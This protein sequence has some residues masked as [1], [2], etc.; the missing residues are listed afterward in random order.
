MTMAYTTCST[1]GSVTGHASPVTSKPSDKRDPRRAFTLI[2][3]LVVVA[4]IALLVSILLP[5]LAGAR[6]KAQEVQCATNLRTCGQSTAYYLEAN[7]DT[8]FHTNW[9]SL[10]HK[11]VTRYSKKKVADW[12]DPNMAASCEF[13]LCPGDSFYHQSSEVS[14]LIN[15]TPNRVV[16][17]LSYGVNDS[18]LCPVKD[19][20]LGQVLS[21]NLPNPFAGYS[22]EAF[23]AIKSAKIKGYDGKDQWIQTGMRKSGSVPRPADV[24]LLMDAGDDDMEIGR[25]DFRQEKEYHNKRELQVHHKTGDNFLYADY[26]VNYR[27]YARSAYQRNAPPFPWSWLP[28]KTGRA[29]TRTTNPIDAYLYPDDYPY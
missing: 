21:A 1:G 11:Y 17:A 29:V 23:L 2:E 7:R 3:V 5:S 8:Y 26:H 25:W 4:I 20:M 18:L 16:Y 13:Y 15:G 10:I 24:L 19:G 22:G 6:R 9:S 12:Q 28:M 27:R 14:I